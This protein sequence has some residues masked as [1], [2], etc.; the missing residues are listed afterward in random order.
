[1]PPST[2]SGV[3]PL[4]ADELVS[5]IPGHITTQ[6]PLNEWEQLNTIQADLWARG[7]VRDVLTEGFVRRNEMGDV[8]QRYIGALQLADRGDIALLLA[9]ARS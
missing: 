4:D 8:R 6:S 9:F 3:T 1:M 2:P 7:R 5:L